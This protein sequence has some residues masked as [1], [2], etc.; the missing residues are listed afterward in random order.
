MQSENDDGKKS[1]VMATAT[2]LQYD[3]NFLFVIAII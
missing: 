1:E 2:M 3:N